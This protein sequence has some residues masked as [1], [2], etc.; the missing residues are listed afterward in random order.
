[1]PNPPICETLHLDQR[2]L[3]PK[4]SNVSADVP[5]DIRN[6]RN[7]RGRRGRISANP[8]ATRRRSAIFST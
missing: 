5:A 2:K 7:V 6:V 4:Y 3:P 1:M 8:D